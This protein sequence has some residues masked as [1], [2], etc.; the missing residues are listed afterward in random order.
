MNGPL[1]QSDRAKFQPLRTAAELEAL[2]LEAAQ[3][4]HMVVWPSHLIEKR[5]EI[6][7]Y[8]SFG[9]VALINL[10]AHSQRMTSRDSLTL[11]RQLEHAAAA[12][13]YPAVCVPCASNSPFRPLM[14]RQGYQYL[15][16]SGFFV[17]E[18]KPKAKG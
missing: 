5:G 18:L 15:F 9:N 17:K 6:A 12:A 8:A 7:G 4:N 10:W 1:I 11:W 2:V 16:E 13:G 14:A 3:D